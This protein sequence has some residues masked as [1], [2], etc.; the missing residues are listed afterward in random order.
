MTK[1]KMIGIGFLTDGDREYLIL[2]DEPKLP[3][4]QAAILSVM[5]LYVARR[6]FVEKSE[7]GILGGKDLFLTPH[8][9]SL[10]GDY[11]CTI[12]WFPEPREFEV[13]DRWE[14]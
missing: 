8:W 13:E 5:D 10:Y 2:A 14:K 11:P 7:D 4:H 3:T 9:I 6:Y 1:K 12:E